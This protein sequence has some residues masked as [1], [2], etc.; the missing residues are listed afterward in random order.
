MD[1]DMEGNHSTGHNA[2]S[3]RKLQFKEELRELKV[4]LNGADF[5]D[6]HSPLGRADAE[7]SLQV[8]SRRRPRK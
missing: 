5:Q 6:L 3:V 7:T 4:S 1:E 2:E 8:L